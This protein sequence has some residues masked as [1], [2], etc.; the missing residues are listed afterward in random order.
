MDKKFAASGWSAIHFELWPV[1]WLLRRAISARAGMFPGEVLDYGCGSKPYEKLFSADRYV[2]VDVFVSGHPVERK[3]ADVYFDGHRVPFADGSF[4]GV[5]AF[6]VLEHVPELRESV[7]EMVRLVRPGG[8]LMITTPFC[9]PEHEVPY[10]FARWT[11]FALRKAF[12][13]SGCDVIEIVKLGNSLTVVFQMALLFAV[14]KLVFHRLPVVSVLMRVFWCLLFNGLVAVVSSLGKGTDGLY[15][16][17][18]VVARKL[19]LSPAS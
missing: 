5:V 13:E 18:L 9:W 11:Q 3:L 19:P 10:D 17:T 15:L 6:E 4:D 14:R 8:L 12:E 2:G 16:S 7:G 1:R